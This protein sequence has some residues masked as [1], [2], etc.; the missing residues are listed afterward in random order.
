M[1]G[2]IRVAVRNAL[3]LLIELV[4][5]KQAL[6]EGVT[7][8]AHTYGYD[9]TTFVTIPQGGQISIGGYCSIARGVRILG[10][11]EHPMDLVSTYPLRTAL[12]RN[13]G[14][15]YDDYSKGP[16]RIGNDVWLGLE[17]VILSGVN[18]GDGAVVGARAVVT[19]EVPPYAIVA[20]NPARIVRY[21]FSPEQIKELLRIAWWNWSEQKVRQYESDFY[22]DIDSFLKKHAH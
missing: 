12:T 7:V 16:T 2:R 21:R 14:K 13:D 8:G 10:R 20:G 3:R 1:N 15:I 22:G 17:C 19:S 18:V 9:R 4:G 5:G 6:P 11:S